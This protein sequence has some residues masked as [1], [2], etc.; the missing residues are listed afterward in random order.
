MKFLLK[1][2]AIGLFVVTVKAAMDKKEAKEMMRGMC[3]ECKEKENAT[4]A[5]MDT[6]LDEKY[7][8]TREGK[9]L[10]ACMQETFGV[11]SSGQ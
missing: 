3:E 11:V 9:C 2:L 8:E 1:I 10:V 7:P 4:D 6:M 5:D